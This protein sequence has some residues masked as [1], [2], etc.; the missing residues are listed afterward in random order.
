MPDATTDDRAAKADGSAALITIISELKGLD[1]EVCRRTLRAAMVFFGDKPGMPS[2]QE[3]D[4]TSDNDDG[5]YPSGVAKWMKEYGIAADE[6]D[7]AFHFNNGT[8]DILHVPGNSKRDQTLNAYI[9]TGL[10]RYL[11]TGERGFDDPIARRVC[12]RMG[13]YDQG[14]H[15][16]TLKGAHP[17]FS[18]DKRKGYTL[19][20]PGI[21]RG[22]EL[23]KQIAGAAG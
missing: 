6:V 13:C 18:G 12:E 8:F 19:T 15:S 17:E 23:V 14:N 5:T 21:K 20:N 22:A 1:P 16:S 2:P 3:T 11:T 10:G 7:R 4:T 9:L